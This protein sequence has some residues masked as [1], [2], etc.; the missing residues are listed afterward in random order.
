M[1]SRNLL[2]RLSEGNVGACTPGS[3]TVLNSPGELARLDLGLGREEVRT[4]IQSIPSPWA[5]LILFRLA[6]KDPKH[7]ARRLVENE[8]LDALQFLWSANERPNAPLRFEQIRLADI[9]ELASRLGS[10]RVEWWARALTELQ[11]SRQKGT[12]KAF[13]SMTVV[14]A[15]GRPI[16]GS[17]PF[18]I[19]FTAE[20]ASH[21]ARDV[22]GPY[23]R[24]ATG[25]DARDLSER[26]FGFQRYVAQVILP[27]LDDNQKLAHADADAQ[28]LQSETKRWLQEQVQKCRRAAGATRSAQLESPSN[29]DWRAAAATL[30]LEEV[31]GF[32]GAV[33]VFARKSGADM[34]ESE[35]VL[36]SNRRNQSLPL[37]LQPTT[38]NGRYY[39]GAPNVALP[40]NLE[41]LDRETLPQTGTRYPWVYPDKHWFAEQILILAEPLD[42]SNVFG[43]AN[44]KTLYNG[45][46]NYLREPQF[47]LPLK[48]EVLE[49]FTPEELEQ[50]V[51]IDVQPS[52]HV[53]VTLRIPVGPDGRDLTVKRRY[54]ES[55]FFHGATGPSL[56]IWPRFKSA[57]WKDYTLFRRDANEN[58]AQFIAVHGVDGGREL[59]EDS[60]KRNDVAR[61]SSFQTPPEGIEF[62]SLITGGAAAQR[63]GLVLPKYGTAQPVGT[64]QWRVGVDFGTSNT[65]VTIKQT[66]DGAPA[67][68]ETRNM[69]LPLTRATPE[70]C[71][72]LDAYFMPDALV[73]RPFGT[74]VMVFDQLR[75][76]NVHEER[77]GVR[78]NVPFNGNVQTDD[79]NRVTGDLKWSTDPNTRFL[80]TSFLRHVLAVVLAQAAEKGVDPRHVDIVWSYP[81]AYSTGQVNQL[82]AM[83]QQVRT[84]FAERLGGI[85]SITRGLDESRAVLQFFANDQRITAAGDVNVIVDIGGGTSDIAMYGHGRT[86]VL[87]SVMLGGRNLTAQR[88]WAGTAHG[89]RNPFVERFVAWAERNSL[90]DYPL[91]REAVHKYLNDGQDHLAFTYLLQSKWFQRHGAA[92]STET[93]SHNFQALVLYV[94]GALAYYVGLSLREFGKD[95]TPVTVMLAGNGSQYYYWLTDLLQTRAKEFD[96]VLARL[97]LAGMTNNSDHA[98]Q[99][100]LT[101]EPKREVALGL[102][103]RADINGIDVA[104][105]ATGSVAGESFSAKLG[106]QRQERSLTAAQRLTGSET[107]HPDSVAG[108]KWADG[109]MEIERFHKLFCE[110]AKGLTSYGPQWSGNAQRLREAL[111][112]TNARELQQLTRARLQLIASSVDGFRGSL[113]IAEVAAVA[114]KL[115]DQFFGASSE[116][117]RPAPAKQGAGR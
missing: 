43:F 12:Q 49:Y 15:G 83:W 57:E 77:I 32:T 89:Q 70:T 111:L 65:V 110:E 56:T 28:A 50:R 87:D 116:A 26:P 36:R 82:E 46:K 52:G 59:A 11:P 101:T 64:S 2:P 106:D 112:A 93:A 10:E 63:L 58:V 41:A 104:D 80:T 22:T 105:D 21:A 95:Y 68:L 71:A 30:G 40:A 107:I 31:P 54:D 1:S 9:H 61:V 67:V 39:P 33:K 5:R 72:L 7:P 44:Y 66:A 53:E 88:D 114:A 79:H 76:L 60:Q 48:R 51:S 18:T 16:I 17:S 8:L 35:W 84:Y 85:G 14:I 38:F 37:V 100:S 45:S 47:T 4:R 78:V 99:I 55:A 92:F 90:A 73:A 69:T 23:F 109:E 81:R 29:A 13:E 108:L 103:A 91:E 75:T 86:L 96:R 115:Q 19:L 24:Y 25:D 62:T 117:L 6:L 97:V 27:Q 113:F 34:Q 3:W 42:T 94:F 20:D 98:P 74:A 102:V